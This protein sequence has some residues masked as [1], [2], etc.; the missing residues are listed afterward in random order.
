MAAEQPIP[1]ELPPGVVTNQAPLASKARYIDASWVRFAKGKPQL[2]GGYTSL[3]GE[4][5]LL[6]VP[7]GSMVWSDTASRQLIAAGTDKKL[8]VTA[9]SD[10]TPVDLTPWRVH[11]SGL[12]NVLVTSNGL[13]LVTLRYVNHGAEV[14]DYVDVSGAT[15]GNNIDPNGSWRVDSVVDAD[16]VTFLAATNANASGTIGGGGVAVGF[17]ISPGLT[18]PVAGFGWGAGAWGEGTWNTPRSYTTLSFSPRLWTFGSFGDV[19]VACPSGGGLY[20]YDPAG[21]PAGR[22]EA[23][24]TAPTTCSGVVVTSDKIVIAYGSN[25]D[26][27][28]PGAGAPAD[29]DLLQYWASAQGD[30]TDWD[31]TKTYGS[32]GSQSVVN[33]LT[34]GTRIVGAGDLGV[35]STL[36]W[37]DTA[38]YNLQYTGSKYVFNTQLVGKECGL[39]G[40]SA[41][42]IVG[43]SAYWV[44][45]H[46]LFMFN[47]GVSRIPNY[48]DVSEWLIENLRPYYTV[49]TLSWHNERYNEVW[50]AFVPPAA[51]EPT[52]Y[53]AV[54]LND[55][56]WTKGELPAA[57][58]S[59]TRFTGYDARPILL[60]ADGKVYQFDN[61]WTANGAALSWF[62][63]TAPMEI[64]SGQQ[65]IE[66]SGLAIDMKRQKSPII[67]KIEAYDRTPAQPTVIDSMTSSFDPYTQVMDA[68]VSGRSIA[69]RLSGAGTDQ[70]F[71]LGVFKAL[72]APGAARR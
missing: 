72:Q 66:L 64:G 48:E 5:A 43:T 12:A 26:P 23:I 61:G 15:V 58:S 70:D 47:G 40:Q 36:M 41:F 20:S 25:F 9:D 71:R 52:Y 19:L 37:T 39:M 2:I 29:Q 65:W 46:G 56:S 27:A 18:D 13:P 7:R 31:T 59:A 57:M 67:V 51:T 14:G 3:L 45:P 44:G 68:R 17:E 16:H 34:E 42:V 69:L 11:A 54:N 10:Y 50:F 32:Q 21:F 6:G 35:H 49:K 30:Y 22:A 62:L 38:V 53:V 60:G 28:I 24:A 1:L 63:Q 8:Y 4:K 33:R 55:W